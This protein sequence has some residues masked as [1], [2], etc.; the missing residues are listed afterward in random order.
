MPRSTCVTVYYM[1]QRTSKSLL[2]GGL[3]IIAVPY[4]F[5]IYHAAK[6][7]HPRIN[8]QQC[9][10]IE[11]PTSQSSVHK[12]IDQISTYLSSGLKPSNRIPFPSTCLAPAYSA[13]LAR[14]FSRPDRP[15]SFCFSSPM[16][17]PPWLS[18]SVTLNTS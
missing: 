8:H 16:S 6:R 18:P 3:P 7:S 2:V 14:A 13:A 1:V 5:L 4:P 12:R 11:T 10:P 15:S 17:S 9:V